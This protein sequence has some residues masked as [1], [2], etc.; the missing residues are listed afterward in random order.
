MAFVAT[1]ASGAEEMSIVAAKVDPVPLYASPGD[2][3]AVAHTAAS[4]LPLDVREV[5]G[6]FLRVNVGGRDLWV[7]SLSVRVNRKPTAR[8]AAVNNPGTK[9]AGELG[10][11]S[12][13]CK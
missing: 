10:A 13:R 12:E 2:A 9:V 1:F 8:C 6:E 4:T 3:T 5:K 11:G 7:D